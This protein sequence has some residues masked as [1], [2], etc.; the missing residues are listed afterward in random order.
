METSRGYTL[1]EAI[2][3]LSILMIISTLVISA[4]LS[5][6]KV[7][8][9]AQDIRNVHTAAETAME[10]IAREIRFADSVTTGSSV[11]GSNPGTLVLSSIDPVSEA[12]QT[13]TFGIS[14]N[15]ITIQKNSTGAD[16]LT[17]ESVAITNLIFRH[18]ATTTPQAIKI[19][20]GVENTH[21]FYNTVILRRSY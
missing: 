3:Y 14:G 17:P 8:A 20:M 1:I 18:I 4:I 21:N 10:R 13:I 9:E 7:V 5:T 2:V 16:Y 11:L 15:R 19:E 12:A 6:A